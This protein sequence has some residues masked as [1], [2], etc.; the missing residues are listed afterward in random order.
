MTENIFIRDYREIEKFAL[1]AY[2]VRGADSKGRRFPEPEHG[3]RNPFQRDRDRIIHSSA[4]R[5]LE[6][7]TQVFTVFKG[8][9]YRTRLTHTI[10]VSQISRTIARALQLNEDLSEAIALAHDLGHPP[11]GHVGEGILHEIMKNEGGFEHNRQGL[12]VVDFIETRYPDFRGLNL[13]HEVR[14]GIIKHRT[15]YD[16]PEATLELAMQGAPTL[17]AQLVNLAD[18]ITYSCHDMDDGLKS[19][20]LNEDAVAGD[21]L[22]AAALKEAAHPR[23]AESEKMRRYQLV[24]NLINMQVS[25][26]LSCTQK[27]I[28]Q[29]SLNSLADVRERGEG[30]VSFSP[31]MKEM[32]GALKKYLYENFYKHPQVF[33]STH[34]ARKIITGLFEVFNNDFLLIPADIRERASGDPE[35]RIVCDYIAGMTDRF[36]ID[37]HK[38]FYGSEA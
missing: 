19:G 35:R 16:T 22:V 21:A 2:A 3:Y 20:L 1:A 6:S 15:E 11:F 17:E 26:V 4:F 31:E 10:E 33:E 9:Y 36:A 27:K 23:L 13:T 7:K 38:R 29:N 28:V 24:R 8:D 18:E 12:R 32:T 30:L 14:E 34:V 25:D 37:E 5:R